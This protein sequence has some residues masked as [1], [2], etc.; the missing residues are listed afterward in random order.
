M[1]DTS[2]LSSRPRSPTMP[3]F[4]PAL[5][6]DTSASRT[7]ALTHPLS[8]LRATPLSTPLA[9]PRSSPLPIRPSA[10]DSAK[11]LPSIRT[12]SAPTATSHAS[13]ATLDEVWLRRL[14]A[15]VSA[16]GAFPIGAQHDAH[17]LLCELF[18]LLEQ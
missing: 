2:H 18:D 13:H 17:E 3:A 10:E 9:T 4:A 11:P 8:T 16:G 14:H 5:P 6:P 12:A 7:L 15:H 1:Q